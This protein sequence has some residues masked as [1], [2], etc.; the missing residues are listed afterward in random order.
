MGAIKLAPFSNLI[1]VITN[2]EKF[3]NGCKYIE[4]FS[5]VYIPQFHRREVI[6]M[7]RW[8]VPIQ[9][10]VNKVSQELGVDN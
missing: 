6:N 2:R 10:K 1:I 4:V 8:N 9:S 7:V 5:K 3:Y